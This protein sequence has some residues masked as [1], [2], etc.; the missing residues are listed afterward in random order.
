MIRY[1]FNMCTCTDSLRIMVTPFI[2]VLS[3]ALFCTLTS[4][5]ADKKVPQKAFATPERAVN[6]LIDAVRSDKLE[7]LKTILGPGS[8]KLI[9]SGDEIADKSD[10]E[11]FFNA[12]E[13][14]NRIEMVSEKQAVLHVG[15]QDW[16]MPIFVVKKGE[17]WFFDAKTAKDEILNRRIGRNELN[18]MQVCMAYV[19]AQREYAEKDMDED[20]ILE[21][22]QK[23]ESEPGQK[24]GLFWQTK[25]TE[26][27]SPLGPFICRASRE[28]YH[29]RGAFDKPEPYHGYLYKILKGQ[30]KN[31]AGGAFE[32]VV[33]GE[34]IGGFAL[35]AYPARHG[36]SGIMTFIVNQDGDIYEKNL[37]KNTVKIAETMTIFDPDKTWRKVI[38]NTPD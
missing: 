7:E 34:M 22:A 3:I 4:H 27:Q 18:A 28:G 35:V 15:N 6:A 36:A 32:Y 10:R 11:S 31:S 20:G 24:N 2:T 8:E 33:N 38:L 37:G 9:S 26:P 25:D 12:Y 14:K 29:E 16:P 17:Q 1:F 13:E 30:G 19:D 21:Y 23:F 5:A